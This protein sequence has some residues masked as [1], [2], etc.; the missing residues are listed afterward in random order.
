MGLEDTL[1]HMLMMGEQVMTIGDVSRTT[2]LFARIER[3][4]AEQVT[5]VA[6]EL[7]TPR[8]AYLAAIGPVQEEAALIETLQRL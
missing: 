6:R 7:F 2:E 8:R 5:E 1:E 4:S 3:V